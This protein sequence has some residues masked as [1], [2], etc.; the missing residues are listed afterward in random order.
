M[1]GFRRMGGFPGRVFR[2]VRW[3]VSDASVERELRAP[4]RPLDLAAEIGRVRDRHAGWP[5]T[6]HTG[7][8]RLS[9]VTD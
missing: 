8:Q 7:W 2:Q 5:A 1:P 6:D 9:I 3:L 4:T